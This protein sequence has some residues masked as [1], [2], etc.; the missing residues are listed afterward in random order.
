MVRVSLKS[1]GATA[2]A[3]TVRAEALVCEQTKVVLARRSALNNS[4][5]SWVVSSFGSRQNL[6]FSHMSRPFSWIMALPP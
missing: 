3:S 2:K 6:S 1:R 4:T 5:S